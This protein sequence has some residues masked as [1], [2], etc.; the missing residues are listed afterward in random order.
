VKDVRLKAAR[1]VYAALSNRKLASVGIE[2]PSWED[3]IERHLRASIG[4]T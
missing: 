3:A 1:P 4:A 2:M